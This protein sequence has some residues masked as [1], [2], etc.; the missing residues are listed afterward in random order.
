MQV[1]DWDL[2]SRAVE[3]TLPSRDSQAQHAIVPQAT[4]ADVASNKH[5][6]LPTCVR[7]GWKQDLCHSCPCNQLFIG[8]IDLT[9]SATYPLGL[10]WPTPT[11]S[12]RAGDTRVSMHRPADVG[13]ENA[14]SDK[15]K[16]QP[17]AENKMHFKSF[18]LSTIFSVVVAQDLVSVLKSQ[19]DLST[20]L[21]ALEKIPELTKTVAAACNITILAPTNDAFAC[22][23]PNSEVGKALAAGDTEAITALIAYHVLN[24]TYESTDFKKTPTFVHSLLTPA[25][26]IGGEAVT[27]VTKGQNVE[28]ILN[29]T[30]AEIISGGGKVSSVTQANIQVGGITIHKIDEVLAIPS[31]ASVTAQAAGLTSAVNALTKASLATTVDSVAD[32]TIF[33]PTNEAFKSIP[34]GIDVKTLTNVLTYHAITGSV[35]FSTDLSNTSVASLQGGKIMVT[36]TDA[37]VMVNQAKVV[38]ADVLIA[39][40]VAHV[41]DGVLLPPMTKGRRWIG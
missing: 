36:V 5:R 12:S 2:C 30:A 10:P 7:S 9:D 1:L 34:A 32:L 14:R 16:H 19:P 18:F 28:L 33:V 23:P 20:L 13:S 27:N 8:V 26:T 25:L 41:I 37:G 22:I 40:G 35:L 38:V 4:P 3:H 39:N 21:G 17:S 24:G 15:S 31:K 29:G 6:E 11:I